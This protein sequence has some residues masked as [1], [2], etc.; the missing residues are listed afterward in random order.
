LYRDIPYSTIILSD[1]G[2]NIEN[3]F[4][5][6]NDI[7]SYIKRPITDK[8][9]GLAEF[10]EEWRSVSV[11]KNKTSFIQDFPYESGRSSGRL[12]GLGIYNAIM[13]Q[14]TEILNNTNP[15]IVHSSHSSPLIEKVN[16]NNIFSSAIESTRPVINIVDSNGYTTQVIQTQSIHGN[17]NYS[18]IDNNLF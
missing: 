15:F 5:N 2:I 3:I 1:N 13:V 8:V 12:L 18:V 11:L 4:R 9:K 17:R 14:Y 6:N 10:N 16:I 7:F